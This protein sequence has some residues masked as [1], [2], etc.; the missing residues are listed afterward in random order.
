MARG[1]LL[2]FTDD[3]M[4]VHPRWIE[5]Y[6][7]LFT[8]H[9]G[10]LMLAGGAV[11]PIPHD[12]GTWPPWL[13]QTALADAGLLQHGVERPLVKFEYVWGGNM[14]VPKHVF[15]S[16]G[17]WDETAGLQAEQRVKRED[18]RFYEDTELQDRVRSAGGSTWFCP[19]AVVHHR[20]DR[21]SVTPRRVSSAAFIRG[22]N[23]FWQ[24]ELRVWRQV[25]SMPKRNAIRTALVLA[26]SLAS[27]GLWL[28]L[29][30]FS[31]RREVFERARR[32][33][34]ISGHSLDSLRAGRQSTRL[35]RSA[36]RVVFPTSS[37]LLRL[38]PDVA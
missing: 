9:E 33:A 15:E 27:W 20:V 21:R 11:I 10:E 35:F 3:D 28:V 7:R 4:R 17:L 16:L 6:R 2:L 30:R 25:E 38:T 14:A 8:A 5:S 24:Q 1:S 34:F 26:K 29:F 19:E 13:D 37:L 22:R 32:S 18:S 12:L 36:A 31:Q 23:N